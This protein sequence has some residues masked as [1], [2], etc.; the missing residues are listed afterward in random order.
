MERD[1]N[2]SSSEEI[3]SPDEDNS[4]KGSSNY[5]KVLLRPHVKDLTTNNYENIL[6]IP[7]VVD[8]DAES[9]GVKIDNNMPLSLLNKALINFFF[10]LM[11]SV[12]LENIDVYISRSHPDYCKFFY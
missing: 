9:F 4:S 1:N 11:N 5:T 3:E 2:D 6:E 7:C 10:E 12:G 8:E